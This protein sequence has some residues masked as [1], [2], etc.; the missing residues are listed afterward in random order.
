MSATT[1]STCI[2]P[3]VIFLQPPQPKPIVSHPYQHLQSPA[4][5]SNFAY[6]KPF[7]SISSI[8]HLII[9]LYIHH[10]FIT[11]SFYNNFKCHKNLYR[12]FLLLYTL[13]SIL[14]YNPYISTFNYLSSHQCPYLKCRFALL[15]FSAYKT[16]FNG[17]HTSFVDNFTL[18]TRP[19]PGSI[20]PTIGP[21]A[22]TAPSLSNSPCASNP[23][24]YI[25]SSFS[26][27]SAIYPITPAPRVLIS[28]SPA[29]IALAPFATSPI[30]TSVSM[31]P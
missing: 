23:S 9:L 11:A 5:W 2:K 21:E 16:Y 31:L 1:S 29:A 20:S 14:N 4:V 27:L 26:T 6:Y 13:H 17:R 7:M 25:N 24:Q 30:Y 15:F 12:C 8:K 18:P 28:S 22:T 19:R 10:T 3:L